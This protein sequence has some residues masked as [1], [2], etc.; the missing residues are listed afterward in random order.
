MGKTK[1]YLLGDIYEELDEIKN[2]HLVHVNERI[3]GIHS[4]MKN[5]RTE[6][7][8]E[9]NKIHSEMKDMRTEFQEEIKDIRGEIKDIRGDI[10]SLFGDVS[11][12]KGK[13]DVFLDLA[14]RRETNN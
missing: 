12:I 7:Q 10:K 3:D 2:N 14:T 8:D 5:M 11:Y 6:F 4:E 9:I 1:K 13:I